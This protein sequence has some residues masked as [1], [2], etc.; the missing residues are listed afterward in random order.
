MSQEQNS[1]LISWWNEQSFAA[2]ELFKLEENGDIVLLANSNIRERIIA[3]ISPESGDAVVKTLTDKFKAVEGRIMETEVEWLA[4]EDKLKLADKV[5]STKEYLHH[6][7][8]L[9]DFEKLALLVH[10]WEHTI[11]TL[12]EENYA[13]KLKLAELAEGLAG[14]E[15]WKETTLAFRDIAERWKLSGYVDKGRNDKLWN[16]IEAA[17]KG[18]H[19]R[20]RLHHEDEEK[21][22]LRKLDL[23]IDLVEQAETMAKSEEWKKTTEAFHRLTEEWKTIGHTVNKKNEEL[24]QRFIAA[25]SAF[26]DKKKENFNKIQVQQEQNYITKLALTEKAEALKESRDWNATTKAF[27]TLMEEWKKTGRVPQERGDDLWTRFTASQE[28]FFEAKRQHNEGVNAM[29]ENNYR[30]KSDLL[31]RAEQL[32]Y[33]NHWG[34]ATAGMVELM[35]EWKKIGPV[36]RV[37]GD[38]M[39]EDFNAARKFFFERKDASREQHKQFI[40][41]QKDARVAKARDLVVQL[42]KDIQEEKEKLVD[43]K[44]AIE[45][46]TPGKKANE[47]RAHL[48]KLMADGERQIKR[49][50]EKYAQAKNDLKTPE[51]AEVKKEHK[52]DRKSRTEGAVAEEHNTAGNT[53]ESAVVTEEHES[54][55]QISEPAVE[56]TSDSMETAEPVAENVDNRDDVETSEPETTTVEN[57]A[58]E[59]MTEPVAENRDNGNTIET[60]EPETVT[61]EKISEPE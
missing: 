36:A 55:T 47:L 31:E 50:E 60:S 10:D 14:S 30:L 41:S 38:K 29:F 56:A 22:L 37:H 45:N 43:F 20:K 46:I 16:R 3:R 32:K 54:D 53:S 57:A 24:W 51:P 17:R 1:D 44:A 40:E 25:K 34:E 42:Q 4:A 2:K 19:E 49:L 5:A 15:E 33:S 27:A 61:E 18:F 23:K 8:A 59:E 13:E 26:F 11:Y 7:V 39:W 48:E 28:Q 6:A 52:N 9:G 58:G 21:D 35:E 12:A